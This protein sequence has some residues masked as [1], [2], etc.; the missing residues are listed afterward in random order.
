MADVHNRT[1]YLRGCRCDECKL[2]QSVYTRER[3]QKKNGEA[4][5]SRQL[6]PAKPALE[7]D[8]DDEVLASGG[9][10]FSGVSEEIAGFVGADDHPGLKATALALA[11]ILDTPSAI[12][13][14]A[15][16]AGR[17]M[18]LLS[19]LGKGGKKKPSKLS[20]L[21]GLQGGKSA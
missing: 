12:A 4:L 5:S 21:R 20:E 14:H 10:V 2:A 16:A 18:E 9:S 15:A 6:R 11:R 3:R 1:R 13:Q 8:D 17:L 7:P 19:T